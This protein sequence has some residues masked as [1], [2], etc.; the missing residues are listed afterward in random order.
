[1]TTRRWQLYVLLDVVATWNQQLIIIQSQLGNQ[2]ALYISLGV[3]KLATIFLVQRLFTRDMKKVTMTCHIFTAALV[4]WTIMAAMLVSVGCSPPSMAPKTGSKTCPGIDV[5]YKFVVVTDI[6]T[7]MV[8]VMIPSY[9]TWQLQMSIKLKLQVIAV[10]AF[11]LPLIALA[12]MSLRAWI[13]SLG[14]ENPGADRT[15]AIVFQQVE[16]CVSLLAATLPCLKSF[17]RSF[18]TGSGVKATIGSSNET[19]SNGRNGG[20]GQH[21]G[22]G[23]Q[24]SPVKNSRTASGSGSCSPWKGDDGSIRV[25]PRPFTSARSPPKLMRHASSRGAFESQTTME[26]DRQSQGS[27]KGLFIRRETHWEVTSEEARR[28]SDANSAGVLR[29]A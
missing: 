17:I 7:D 15:P 6:I 26:P 22:D 29:L 3:S 25:N 27:S 5:R 11:R 28:E 12:S 2:V 19:G 24:L 23:Y 10:F 14:G 1:M 21:H 8:L 13:R 20:S 4:V 9:L 18:D 16:L